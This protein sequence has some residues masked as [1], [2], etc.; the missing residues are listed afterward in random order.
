ME[1]GNQNTKILL[2]FSCYHQKEFN[3]Q[4]FAEFINEKDDVISDETE[5]KH[6]DID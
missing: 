6:I 4:I 2:I 3:K 1:K 5:L